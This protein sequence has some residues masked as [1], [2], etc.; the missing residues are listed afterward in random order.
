MRNFPLAA[1]LTAAAI[2]QSSPALATTCPSDLTALNG[3]ITSPHVRASLDRTFDDL[4][5]AAGGLPA[6]IAK[7]EANVARYQ[8][9]LE[10]LTAGSSPALVQLYEEALVVARARLAGLQCRQQ[11]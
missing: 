8:R 6:A 1:L 5:A 7:A 9:D 4:V 2:A 11:D 10:S 3:Q